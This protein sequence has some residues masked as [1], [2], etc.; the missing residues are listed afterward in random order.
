LGYVRTPLQ[1]YAKRSG[2]AITQN[3]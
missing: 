1:F 2:L 3:S